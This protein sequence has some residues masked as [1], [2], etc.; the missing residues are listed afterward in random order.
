M[1]SIESIGRSLIFFGVILIVIG[2]LFFAFGK[3][4]WFGR[5]P[6]DIIIKR[7]GFTVYFPLV[8]MVLVS[9]VLTIIFNLVARR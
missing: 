4:P 1:L 3:I 2:A 5:L 6:G 8:T 9:I 7:E